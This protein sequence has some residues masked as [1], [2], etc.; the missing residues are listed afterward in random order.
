MNNLRFII[1]DGK[2]V[3][4]FEVMK[5]AFS[6]QSPFDAPNLVPTGEW[7]DI[8]IVTVEVEDEG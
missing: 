7:K 2:K 3:L 4:Q 5:P 1:R 6:F 8:P